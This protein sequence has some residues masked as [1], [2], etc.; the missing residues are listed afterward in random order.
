MSFLT[1]G[2]GFFM[3]LPI[4][5]QNTTH[6]PVIAHYQ[7]G[8]IRASTFSDWLAFNG[9]AAETN[10][11]FRLQELVALKMLAA[12]ALSLELTNEMAESVLVNDSLGKWAKIFFQKELHQNTVVP[13]ENLK[14]TLALSRPFQHR[15]RKVRLWNIY[16]RFPVNASDQE[17]QALVQAVEKIRQALLSGQDF[18]SLAMLESHSQTRFNKGILGNVKPGQLRPQ[19]DQIA[20]NMKPG[21]YSHP[22]VTPDGVTL[23]Y[24]ERII[25]PQERSE[26]AFQAT[27]ASRVRERTY[28]RDLRKFMADHANVERVEFHWEALKQKKSQ[29][30]VA[31]LDKRRLSVPQY[32]ALLEQNGIGW[33]QRIPRRPALVK[34]YFQHLLLLQKIRQRPELD[35]ELAFRKTFM[36]ERHRSTLALAKRVQKELKQPELSVMQAI[37][38][39]KKASFK[40][41]QSYRCQI[42]QIPYTN[43]NLP[44]V[45]NQAFELWRRLVAGDLPFEKAIQ[46]HSQHPSKKQKGMLGWLTESEL[47]S[48]GINLVRAAR[49]H[50]SGSLSGLIQEN[51][52]FWILKVLEKRGARQ[53]S[54][55]EAKPKITS[56][57]GQQAASAL[58][59]DIIAVVLGEANIKT[60]SAF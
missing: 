14:K 55:E 32:L 24:C 16:K 9:K 19:V 34:S 35:A 12:E 25:P 41:P 37:Y 17:K 59:S 57:L 39:Q 54:F 7:T 23:L 40:H 58:E 20:M 53:K 22:I 45:H 44:D 31:R 6:D 27:V 8:E 21:T 56:F 38:E 60:T 42:L 15:P 43:Q 18:E 2:L 33:Q 29:A 11:L 13:E 36:I 49:Y 30:I 46:N 3:V 4:Q 48:L 10:R 50:E 51:Q 47:S 52:A 1:L 26:A 5:Q 28:Q